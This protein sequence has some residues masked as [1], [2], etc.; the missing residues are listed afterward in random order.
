MEQPHKYMEMT[1]THKTCI[2]KQPPLSSV[3]LENVILLSNNIF[4]DKN[5]ILVY[6]LYMCTRYRHI[7]SLDTGYSIKI[8]LAFT[9]HVTDI[10][11]AWIQGIP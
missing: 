3:P 8:I 5:L 2:I 10:L 1:G 6:V 7:G 9:A 4:I 11:E